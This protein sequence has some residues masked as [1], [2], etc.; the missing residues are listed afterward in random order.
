MSLKIKSTSNLKA[1]I[2]NAVS[3]LLYVI[4]DFIVFAVGIF[5]VLT[6]FGEKLIYVLM[7]FLI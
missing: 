6:L 7:S 5:S 2:N 4:V 3:S 1:A